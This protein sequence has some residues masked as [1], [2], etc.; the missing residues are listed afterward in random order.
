MIAGAYLQPWAKAWRLLTALRGYLVRHLSGPRC[1]DGLKTDAVKA[2]QRRAFAV[3]SHRSGVQTHPEEEAKPLRTKEPTR[4]LTLAIRVFEAGARSAALAGITETAI[5]P[6]SSDLDAR[7]APTPEWNAHYLDTLKLIEGW[8][9]DEEQSAAD[10]F[11]MK[12]NTYNLLARLTP[13][14]PARDNAIRTYLAFV[15]P[16][17]RTSLRKP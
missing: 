5:S 12:A 17:L 2:F 7:R 9:V 14:G 10:Y 6:A 16:A 8:K 3:Q 11:C 4:S 13:P 15:R 1:S